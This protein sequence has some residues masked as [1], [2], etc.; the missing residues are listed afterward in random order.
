MKNIIY[1]LTG[2]ILALSSCDPM[3]DVYAELDNLA[4]TQVVHTLSDADYRFFKDKQGVPAYV[5]TGLYFK[6]E[7]EAATAIPLFL[8]AYY[9]DLKDGSS[10]SVNYN[11]YRYAFTNNSISDRFP[12]YTLATTDYALGGTNFTNF[13]RWSQIETF[14]KAKYTRSVDDKTAL[15]DGSLTTLTF[16]AFNTNTNPTSKQVTDVYFYKNGQWYDT[17]LVSPEEYTSVDRGRFNNFIAADQAILPDY[18]NKFLK[19]KIVGAKINDLIYVSFSNRP[20][21]TTTQD[22]MGMVYDGANWVKAVD[23]ATGRETS[24]LKFAKDD[25]KWIADRTIEYTLT[26]TDYTEIGKIVTDAGAKA[27]IERY[28]NFDLRLFTEDDVIKYLAARLKTL[29]GNASVGMKYKVFY[30]TFNPSGTDDLTFIVN[31]AGNFEVVK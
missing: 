23:N 24:T 31:A 28:G 6:S 9:G 26:T 27:S 13:D 20:Q 8:N 25:G 17:Y 11:R 15:K 30:K 5:N 29:F 22:V 21:S 18:F 4:T 3:D 16:T 19:A 1:S 14:L 7:D 10:V 2:L 12:A